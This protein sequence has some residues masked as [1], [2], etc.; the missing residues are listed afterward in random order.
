M[1]MTV[2]RLALKS[3]WRRV[4]RRVPGHLGSG[5]FFHLKELHDAATVEQYRTNCQRL[6]FLD[7]EIDAL[8]LRAWYGTAG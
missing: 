8:A 6:Q 7:A 2:G 1:L 5:W 3:G 4:A